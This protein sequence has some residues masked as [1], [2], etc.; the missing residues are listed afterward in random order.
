MDI[1]KY[2]SNKKNI[3]DKALDELLPSVEEY[4]N[5]IHK[6][7]RYSIFSGGKRIRPI[8]VIASAEVVGGYT[9]DIIPIACGIEAIHTYSL[10]HDDLPSLDNDDYR[11]GKLSN[12]KKF[13]EETAILAGDALL[14]FAFEI[15][16]RS[17]NIAPA[18]DILQ[19]VHEVAKYCG[20]RGMI[21]GQMV[22]LK[23]EGKIIDAKTLNFIHNN[24]TGA[25]IVASVRT[26]AICS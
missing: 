7:M 23:S 8:L 12:H 5:L 2:L 25:L 6:A 1:G 19:M 10:I 13:G 3:I 18:N 9:D 15:F 4:P 21:G 26:G 16:S 24:K 17:D 20:T 11:R 22:D 14:T